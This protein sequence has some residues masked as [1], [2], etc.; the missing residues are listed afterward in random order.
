MAK[1]S[2]QKI[3][4]WDD[5]EKKLTTLNK[6]EKGD[7]FEYLTKYYLKIDVKYM[8]MMRFGYY[9]NSPIKKESI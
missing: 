8:R 3:F 7:Y 4:S 9:R 2:F 5:F 1:P 6:K